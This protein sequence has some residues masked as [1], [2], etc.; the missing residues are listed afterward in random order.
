MNMSAA[1]LD[2]AINSTRPVVKTYT[3]HQG[4]INDVDFHPTSTFVASA[5]RDCTIGLFDY[6]RPT[7]KM[8]R[9]IDDVFSIRSI[10]FHPSGDFLLVGTEDPVVRI[11]D[12]NTL[13]AYLNP[14]AEQH[15][16]AALTMVR[17]SP[18]GDCFVTSSRDGS[19][20]VWD[21]VSCQCVRTIRHAHSGAS[22]S[23]ICFNSRGTQILSSGQDN[24]ARLYDLASGALLTRYDGG[25][26]S[27]TRVNASFSP[28]GEFVLMP[29]ERS[30]SIS[31]WRTDPADT[32]NTPIQFSSQHTRSVKFIAVSPC[33]QNFMT[34]SEDTR[35]RF[36]FVPDQALA[37]SESMQ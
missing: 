22:V 16:T 28:C 17:W 19:I 23:S 5:S 7:K 36:W 4:A 3:D 8:S 30:R 1:E 35:G 2:E 33:E 14:Q 26:H 25:G 21:T 12:V 6:A 9:K 32:D 15:H 13:Q 11:Y 18:R 29:D 31:V 20:K 34:C 10:H 37:S 24:S 27:R